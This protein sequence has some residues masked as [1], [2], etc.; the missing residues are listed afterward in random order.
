MQ[1]A[2][3][4]IR[5]RIVDAAREEFLEKGFEKASIRTIT[6]RAKTSKSNLYNYFKDKNELFYSV[7]EPTLAKI[8]KGLEA[9]KAS[10]ASKGEGSYAREA[11]QRVIGTVMAFMAENLTDIKLLLFR[12][13]GSSL[14]NFKNEV[15]DVFT[16]IM[17]SWVR[18]V[19]PDKE[20]SRLF[21]RCVS[22]FYISTVEQTILYGKAYGA[23]K[24]QF[25]KILKEFTDFVYNGWKGVFQQER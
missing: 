6:A 20:I 16:D 18:S 22:N 24:D 25:G 11:Q 15:T 4:E 21:V 1:F 14:E 9:A 3:D 7:L 13:Q 17:D 19:S 2:K 10:G 23:S 8:Q 5:Q 12:A